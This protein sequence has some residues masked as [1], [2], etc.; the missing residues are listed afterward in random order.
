M[1]HRLPPLRECQSRPLRRLRRRAFTLT[2]V[3]VAML[4]MTAVLSATWSLVNTFRD[5]FERSQSRAERSQLIRAVQQM[6]DDDLRSGLVRRGRRPNGNAMASGRA[7]AGQAGNA[8]DGPTGRADG[9]AT[10]PGNDNRLSAA[11]GS[12]G[13]PDAEPDARATQGI[14]DPNTA[15]PADGLAGVSGVGSSP[16]GDATVRR[17]EDMAGIDSPSRDARQFSMTFQAETDQIAQGEWLANEVLFL[18]TGSALVCD[19]L[20][21]AEDSTQPAWT[22][23]TSSPMSP[24]SFE[25]PDG[26]SG[27]RVTGRDA[28]RGGSPEEFADIPEYSRR[29]VYV[30]TDPESAMRTGRA[31]GLIRVE[32][33]N[34]PMAMIRTLA[35]D[36]ADLYALVQPL[37]GVQQALK[38]PDGSGGMSDASPGGLEGI[39][40][41]GNQADSALSASGMGLV[42]E[43]PRMDYVPE[44][45]AFRLRYHDGQGW[46][47]RWDSRQEQE[48]PVAVEMRFLFEFPRAVNGGA[49]QEVVDV[50]SA[51]PENGD[52]GNPV[53]GPWSAEMGEA[54]LAG[55]ALDANPDDRMRSAQTVPIEDHRYVILLSSPP[56]L[57]SSQAMTGRGSGDATSSDPFSST[58]GSMNEGMLTPDDRAGGVTP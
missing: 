43:P 9:D 49:G 16:D 53:A 19:I 10:N 24:S 55:G 15:Q 34:R 48:L 4:L 42:M 45:K 29:I 31:P 20:S 37:T 11:T 32:L 2:E 38:A 14:G 8:S 6:M 23:A 39:S 56:K 40:F 26:E 51:N 35:P 54:W 25:S 46:R 57:R 27:F 5:R 47:E 36:R 28:F 13:G 7:N 3:V 44:V 1:N 30:F 21:P 50:G 58:R 22:A 17:E 18:G 33:R 12:E 52:A 41:A